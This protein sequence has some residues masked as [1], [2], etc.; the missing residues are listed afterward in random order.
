MKSEKLIGL[1]IL[2]LIIT[3]CSVK[4]PPVGK[5]VIPNEDEYIIKALLYEKNGDYNTSI[6]IYEFL[7]RK[8]KKPVYYEKLVENL[9]FQKKYEEVIKKAEEFLKKKFDKKIF[10]YEIFALLNLKKYDKA[11]KLLLTKLNKKDDFFYSMMSFI[12]IKEQK[13]K[14]ALYYMKSLY[15]LKPTKEVLLNLADLLIELKRYNEALA[16]LR[17]HL[18]LYGC[19]FDICKRMALIYKSLYDYKNLAAIYEKLG[20]F[21]KKYYILALNIYIQQGDFKSAEKLIKKYSL[22]DEYLMILYL[23]KKDFRKAAFLA[24]KLYN[25]TADNRYLLKYCEYLYHDT[26]SKKEI[27]DIAKKLEYLLTFYPTP[28][29]YNF[30][31]YLLIKYDL[32][33]KKG[34]EYVQKALMADPE[35]MEYI[36]SLA[37][38][39]YKLGKCKKAWDIIQYIKLNDKE[40]LEHKKKIKECVEKSPKGKK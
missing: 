16:Y 18:G 1:L 14:E 35:N 5:K 10:E 26:P 24:L 12:L 33:V 2:F 8:T 34:L 39:Y 6:K 22:G 21:D 38:G 25:K 28:Y 19:E 11:K 23:Q 32:D 15:A 4:Q 30:L 9:Y 37:W 40:I 3:G 36:D 17:T 20:K 7:Y 29:M 13:F 27:K 31:G